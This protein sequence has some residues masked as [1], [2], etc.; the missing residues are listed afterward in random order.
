MIF[1]I[2]SGTYKK[3]P[4]DRLT[5]HYVGRIADG[6]PSTRY[7]GGRL[8]TRFQRGSLTPLE[9]RKDMRNSINKSTP[10]GAIC[11]FSQTVEE[12]LAEAVEFM[13]G[14]ELQARL[15]DIDAQ[16]RAS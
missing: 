9:K 7:R 6:P 5:P 3:V 10:P 1:E 15:F 8:S 2:S 13:I 4:S 11:T 12:Q 14:E 16:L